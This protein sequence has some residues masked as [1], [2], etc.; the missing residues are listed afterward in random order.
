MITPLV[1]IVSLSNTGNQ[2]IKSWMSSNSSHIHPLTLELPAL[3]RRKKCCG[4]NSAC[5]FDRLTIK[6]ADNKDRHKILNEFEFQP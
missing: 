1:L 5:I 6:L 2:G 3:E 4:Y